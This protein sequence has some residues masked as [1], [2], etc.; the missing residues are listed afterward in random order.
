MSSVSAS[1]MPLIKIKDTEFSQAALV[2]FS[3]NSRQ[4]AR[5]E[6]PTI[7]FSSRKNGEKP[8]DV[9]NA[10]IATE[11]RFGEYFD[12]STHAAVI[13][14]MM[15]RFG[16]SPTDVFDQ[17]TPVA[18]GYDVTMKDGFS[19]HLTQ[20]ELQRATRASRFAG[21]DPGAITDANF[22]FAAFVKRKQLE[23]PYSSMGNGFDAALAKT[24]EGETSQR[25][26]KGMGMVGF[27]QDVSTDQMQAKGAVGVV[28]TRNFGA[29]LVLEGRQ[30]D[31]QRQE[32]V[33]RTYGYM[34]TGDDVTD[35]D[36]SI[37]QG[38]VSVSNVSVGVKP[39]DIW[40]GFYQGVEG[41]CVTVSAIKAAMMK[42][43]QN[44]TSIYKNI[45]ETA[46]GYHVSMR[47]GHS[48]HLTFDELKKA[49]Q[50]SNLAGPDKA[51]LKD[52]NFLYAVSAKRAMKENH[53]FR[54]AESFET[55]MQTLNNGEYPGEAFRRLGLHAYIRPSTAGELAKGALGTLASGGHSVAVVNGSLD[56]YGSKSSLASSHWNN[57]GYTAIRLV[58]TTPA[59]A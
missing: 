38:S 25:A 18:G 46:D 55:A 51:L 53:E 56:W 42:F 37:E 49:E 7:N 6:V 34:L 45:R 59:T 19:V 20:D 47:D 32:P 48:L 8:K 1:C 11:R 16:Q 17:V 35:D 12:V 15:L 29:G 24:L 22:I 52:A 57:P 30:H 54:A 39:G 44:P 5:G 23:G 31:H 21:N 50:G 9:T 4:P 28:D 33:R 41:N 3:E 10:F 58:D 26:L 14:M 43:G 40:G 36:Y 2:P 13:K 27:M